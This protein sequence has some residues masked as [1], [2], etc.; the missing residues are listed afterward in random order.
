[1][2]FGNPRAFTHPVD[3]NHAIIT[4]VPSRSNAGDRWNQTSIVKF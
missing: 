2:R 4:M 1:M 3:V